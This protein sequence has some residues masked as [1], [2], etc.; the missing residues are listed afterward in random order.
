MDGWLFFFFQIQDDLS[1]H[2][3]EF[4]WRYKP[5]G[6]QNPGRGT[7]LHQW[8]QVWQ[9]Q[10]LYSI[11]TDTLCFG[12]GIPVMLSLSSLCS[13]NI[14]MSVEK[15]CPWQKCTMRKLQIQ[16]CKKQQIKLYEF[17]R[18]QREGMLKLK[19]EYIRR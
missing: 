15:V 17:I 5:R 11:S 8:C 2:M 18:I 10:N 6:Y 7:R 16:M 9:H 19:S 14:N 12:T 1:V 3:A 4:P 13:N